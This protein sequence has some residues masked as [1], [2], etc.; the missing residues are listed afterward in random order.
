MEEIENLSTDNVIF[1]GVIVLK[2]SFVQ[3]AKKLKSHSALLREIRD[4]QAEIA[5]LE[6]EI[7]RLSSELEP[8]KDLAGSWSMAMVLMAS[9]WDFFLSKNVSGAWW[10]RFSK[11]DHGTEPCCI[12]DGRTA[13]MAIKKAATRAMDW[14][15]SEAERV[16]HE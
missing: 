14:D 4:L 12:Q 8:V 13:S 10:V 9:G 2:D 16:K 6:G 1:E 3:Q 7:T 5:Q 11:G 15:N